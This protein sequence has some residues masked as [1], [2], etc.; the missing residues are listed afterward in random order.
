MP[1]QCALTL[2]SLGGAGGWEDWSGGGHTRR[3][4]S[5]PEGSREASA[6]EGQGREEIGVDAW[7]AEEVHSRALG[8]G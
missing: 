3:A 4:R 8:M 6:A 5:L 1:E 2:W 7:E